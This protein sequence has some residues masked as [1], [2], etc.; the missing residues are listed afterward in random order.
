MTSLHDANLVLY[1]YWHCNVNQNFLI[2]GFCGIEALIG[3]VHS[4]REWQL[5][6]ERIYPQPKE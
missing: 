2:V 1:Y 3:N 5:V 6:L 4:C